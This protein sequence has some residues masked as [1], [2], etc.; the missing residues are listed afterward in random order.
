MSPS[1]FTTDRFEKNP[2]CPAL[3]EPTI[4]SSSKFASIPLRD[5]VPCCGQMVRRFR[6]P[7][8]T[9]D[10]YD[11]DESD[12]RHGTVTLRFARHHIH[13]EDCEHD[14]PINKSCR[15]I[16]EEVIAKHPKCDY[17][18]NDDRHAQGEADQAKCYAIVLADLEAHPEQRRERREH[19]HDSQDIEKVGTRN[20]QREEHKR[21]VVERSQAE[22]IRG[23]A[24]HEGTHREEAAARQLK[25]PEQR[26]CADR[27]RNST[28]HIRPQGERPHAGRAGLSRIQSSV[29]RQKQQNHKGC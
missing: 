21:P 26:G 13:G 8:H 15:Q 5:F 4:A 6:Q 24:L 11:Y 28:C 9:H 29:N 18:M 20:A 22:P 3:N 27:N 17:R 10:R 19:C 23:V 2:N 1:R 25:K 16:P 7:P 12:R 14:R